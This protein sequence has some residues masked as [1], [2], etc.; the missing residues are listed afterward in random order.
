MAGG[1]AK[2]SIVIKLVSMAGTGFFYVTR[3]N[4]KKQT[5]LMCMKH[6]PV[7][8]THVLFKRDKDVLSIISPT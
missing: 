2:G 1:K 6:D 4:P 8:N 5:K 7:V 3:K